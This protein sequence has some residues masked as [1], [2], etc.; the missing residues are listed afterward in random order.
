MA[1]AGRRS[2]KTELAKRKLVRSLSTRKPWADPRYFAAAPTRDQ[3]KRIFWNDFKRM[4]PRSWIKRISESELIIYTVYGSELHVIGMDKPQRIEGT[5]WDGG[6]L[7]EY[8]NMK[9]EAWVENV[10]PALSDRM[11]WCWLIGVPEGINHYKDLADDAA[12]GKFPDMGFYTWHSADILPAEEIAAAKAM[13]DA[14]TFRQEYEA[15][16]ESATGR[17][18]Y[19]HRRELHRDPDIE[20]DYTKP[21]ILCTDFNV[22]PCVWGVLQTDWDRVWLLDEIMGRDTN[23]AE[24]AGRFIERYGASHL[25][26]VKMG[27]RSM[28][29]PGVYVY[30]DASGGHRNTTGKSDYAI[31]ADMG[32]KDQR[33]RRANPAVKDRVNAVNSMLQTADGQV[34]LTYHPRCGQL[35]KD[36]EGVAWLKGVGDIDKRDG[37]RT[38]ASDGLGYFIEKEF[39]L[40]RFKE[41]E[42]MRYLK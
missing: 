39:P 16:F 17:V 1:P 34:R 19:P 9:A 2:G 31:L 26:E 15:T 8:A 40:R 5:P 20:L 18:Y 3:A 37:D 25:G 13:M 14:R 12:S 30:G 6:V 27:R 21:L 35:E 24:M 10:R 7:D 11:G 42:T 23:T 29:R 41:D 36:F 33:I 4:V 28:S 38:H 32:L 22:D